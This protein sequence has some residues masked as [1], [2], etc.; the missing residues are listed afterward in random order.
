MRVLFAISPGLDHLYPAIG[1]AWAFR[2]AGHT[3]A[4]ATSGESIAAAANAGF[5]VRDVASGTQ[6]DFDAIFPK[7]GTQ[8]ERA[9]NM[10]ERGRTMAKSGVTP[11][12]I[13]EKFGRVSDLMAE[14]TL[15]FAEMWRPD[16]IVYSRLQGAGLLAARALG[17]PAVENG[18]SFLRE[19]D[20]PGRLLPHLAP[21]FER[22]GV[23]VELPEVTPV[24]FAPERM[25]HGEGEGL[26][27][28]FVP[29]HGGGLMPDWLAVPKE[30]PRVCITLG[31]TVP[32]VAGV[33]SVASVLDAAA[34]V[35][36]EFILA[37][38]D[39]VDFTP[40]GTL[41]DNV[42]VVGWTPLSTLLMSCDGI[43]HHGGAGTTLASAHAGVPQL[44]MPHG[45]D[46]WINAGIV[47]RCGFGISR[48]PEDVDSTVLDY[49]V[50]DEGLRKSV[51]DV[52]AELARQPGPDQLVPHL[53]ALTERT[54]VRG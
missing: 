47:E 54:G 44:A 36:A 23:P 17:I 46:N 25:M 16:L 53:V 40:L 1:L 32:F 39:K 31:T 13:L 20:L 42:R 21:V 33:G 10:R 5:P 15:A 29:Y 4:V 52:A 24:Y 37:L 8:E 26:T 49:L 38:G 51:G 2:T 35:D 11:E 27:A 43:I 45:A 50:N 48:D 18:Y 22:L 34:G 9:R 6:A 12:I 19:G 7:S 28:R 41:P 30:R 14:R 3:V